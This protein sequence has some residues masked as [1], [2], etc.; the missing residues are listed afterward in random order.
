[1]FGRQAS[2]SVV[3]ASCGRL[4]GVRDEVCLNCGRR[5]PALWGFS[6]VLRRLGADLGFTKLLIGGCVALYVAS[7]LMS[8]GAFQPRGLLGLLSPR[9]E[10]LFLLGASGPVPV[11]GLGH[12]WTLLS[13]AWLHGS[14]LHIFFNLMWVRQLAPPVA[15]LYGA[16]RMILIWTAGSITGFLASS[17]A[18]AFLPAVPFLSSRAG[19]T[20]GASA[21]IFGLL[22]ALL[23]Y[24]RRSGHSAMRQQVWGWTLAGLL[25]GLVVPGIDNW[26]HLGGLGG[27][28]ALARALDPLRPERIDHVLGALLCL[29][30]TVAAI[31][32]SVV[33]GLSLSAIQ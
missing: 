2:G 23:V 13:A 16:G 9:L 1:M 6:P 14:L 3:C 24:G 28:A 11:F 17:A 21:S 31:V 8:P 18:G 15:E 30:A 25:F 22:G 7:L 4:V 10:A 29:L 26:A 32:A 12:W 27:G 19:F 5:N 33:A 20:V